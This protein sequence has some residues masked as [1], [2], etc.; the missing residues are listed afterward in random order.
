MSFLQSDGFQMDGQESM[1]FHIESQSESREIKTR[2]LRSI[3]E[4]LKERSSGFH[5]FP[6]SAT[7]LFAGWLSGCTGLGSRLINFFLRHGASVLLVKLPPVSSFFIPG[8]AR[9]AV[10]CPWR[11]PFG[12]L[13]QLHL[14]VRFSLMNGVGGVMQISPEIGVGSLVHFYNALPIQHPVNNLKNMSSGG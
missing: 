10:C 1:G 13:C 14:V 2:S 6:S 8:S 11:F 3:L 12:V 5:L 4:N 9:L 7:V